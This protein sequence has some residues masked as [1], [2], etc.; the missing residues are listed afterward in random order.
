[1]PLDAS[2][3]LPWRRPGRA[4]PVSSTDSS[5]IVRG[6]RARPGKPEPMDAS[7][8]RAVNR[9]AARTGWAHP[10]FIAYAKY[11]VVVFAALLL[12]GWWLARRRADI[13]AIASVLWGGAA[14]LVAL[15]VGQLIGHAVDRARP[16]AVMPTAHVLITRPSGL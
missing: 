12:T 13:D 3:E 1:M 11:G 16:Y 15:G 7:L 14:A 6:R 8:Y 9:L 10:L 4:N 2:P 5:A